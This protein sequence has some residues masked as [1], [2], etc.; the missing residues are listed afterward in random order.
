MNFNLVLIA[1]LDFTKTNKGEI[2]IFL[3]IMKF[4][5]YISFKDKKQNKFWVLDEQVLFK[6]LNIVYN[7]NFSLNH[8]LFCHTYH[9]MESE[10]MK[11]KIPRFEICSFILLK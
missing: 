8:I 7:I 10:Y 4:T 2:N 9:A 5:I 6:K 3:I 1:A 11:E